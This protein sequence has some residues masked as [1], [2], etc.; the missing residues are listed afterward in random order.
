MS[1]TGLG[2]SGGGPI[3][4]GLFHAWLAFGKLLIEK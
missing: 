2:R 3:V 4:R 1:N